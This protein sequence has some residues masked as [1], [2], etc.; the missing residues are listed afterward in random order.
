MSDLQQVRAEEVP[1]DVIGGSGGE[2]NQETGNQ[3]TG[4]LKKMALAF[5]RDEHRRKLAYCSILCGCSCIGVKA[6]TYSLK[7][8]LAKDPEVAA[9]FSKR[10]QK[11]GVISILTWFGLL[12]TLFLLVVLV[13]YL[14]TLTN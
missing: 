6:L 8:E 14:V 10:A 5:F 12:G 4:G 3:R 11:F 13:S 1:L 2:Q 9:A 7:A